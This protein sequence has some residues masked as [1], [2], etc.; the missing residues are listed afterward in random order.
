MK[1]FLLFVLCFFC[2]NVY[3]EPANDSFLDDALYKCVIDAYNNENGLDKDYSYSILPE[4]LVTIKNLDCSDYKGEID[5]LT[6]LS[7]MIGLTSINLS[8]NTFLGGTLKL[9]KSAGSL[10]SNIKLPSNLKI[11]DKTYSVENK[12]VAKIDGDKV[13]PLANGSTYV[14]MKGK[15]NGNEI[16]EK[17]LVAVNGG[18]VVRNSDAT[19]SSLTISNNS[20]AFDKSVNT[21][22]V[23]YDKSV[24]KAQV[25]AKLTSNSSSFVEGYGPREVELKTGQNPIYI[26]VKAQDGTINVYTILAIR[27]DGSDTSNKLANIELSA[28]NIDFDSDKFTYDFKVDSNVDELIIK[29]VPHSSLATVKIDNTSLRVGNN[30]ISIVVTAESGATQTYTLNVT[31]EDYD[32]E[33]NYLTNISIDGYNLNFSKDKFNY[34][35]E[36]KKEKSLNIQVTKEVDSATYVVLGNNDLIDGST[37]TINVFDSAGSMRKY[38]INIKKLATASIDMSDIDYRLIVIAV[39]FITIIILIIIAINQRRNRSDKP[40][41]VKMNKT[42]NVTPTNKGG[43]NT[44]RNCGTINDDKSAKCYVCG[45]NL[46]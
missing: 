35:L 29:A 21:Y 6:G 11:T 38:N 46:R 26:K 27:S 13:Y 31:R 4:E 7:K 3:A 39:E 5:D 40:R 19:L 23:T 24:N 45:N 16:V 25:D 37:I 1:K 18:T 41:K 2:V 9:N 33:E 34:D 42:V 14:T 17:Y 28:G 22:T 8:G 15:I 30:K 10:I 12:T 44:C 32:S 43:V 36:I 20:F